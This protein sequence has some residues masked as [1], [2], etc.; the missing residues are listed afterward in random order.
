MRA[1]V[2]THVLR[3]YHGEMSPRIAQLRAECGSCKTSNPIFMSPNNSFT[4]WWVDKFLPIIDS[5]KSIVFW[6]PGTLMRAKRLTMK[7]EEV[8]VIEHGENINVTNPFFALLDGDHGFEKENFF[9]L[10]AEV[11]DTDGRV[12]F[13]E[14]QVEGGPLEVIFWFPIEFSM[15]YDVPVTQIDFCYHGDLRWYKHVNAGSPNIPQNPTK[16]TFRGIFIWVANQL[17][18]N[19]N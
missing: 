7:S 9:V 4:L 3:A 16:F 2:P 17:S 12:V 10:A 1:T 18:C 19:K 5:N 6:Y 15:V 8:A 11:V 13:C 14:G